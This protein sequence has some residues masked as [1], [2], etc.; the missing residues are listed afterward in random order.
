MS[1]TPS[2]ATLAHM[3]QRK[4]ALVEPEVKARLVR[5]G[6]TETEVHFI[7]DGVVKTKHLKPGMVVRPFVHG[8]ARGGEREVGEVKRIGNGATHHVSW[9]TPHPEGEW[10][11]A[12]RWYCEALDGAP[13]TKT[14]R[15]PALVPY[16]EV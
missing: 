5:P 3:L 9:T 11:A 4:T 8:K 10:A 6:L 14:V 12:Y 1:S 7:H 16:E 13:V 15:R 2:P